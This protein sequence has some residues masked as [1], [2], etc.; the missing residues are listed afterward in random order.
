MF[1]GHVGAAIAIGRAE[2]RVNVGVFVLAAL[3][4]DGLLWLFVLLGWETVTIP[5]DFTTTHQPEFGFPYSH[6]LLA[7]IVWSAVAGVVA[8]PWIWGLKEDRWRAAA[9]IAGAAFSHWLLDALVHV[10]EL[11]LTGAGSPMVGLGLWQSMPVALVV[12]GFIV[13]AG[14]WLFIPGSELS[15]GRKVALTVLSLVILAFTLVGMTLAPAPPSATAMAASSLV[16]ILVVCALACWIGRLPEGRK[17]CTR[18][19]DLDSG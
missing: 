1:A 4:L 12:E 8:L 19:T 6:G 3:L 2:R 18:Q 15:R 10:P 5:A 17:V 9:L 11:P 7:G 16:T 13:L 14:L